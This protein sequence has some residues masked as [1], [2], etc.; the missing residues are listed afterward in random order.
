MCAFSLSRSSVLHVENTPRGNRGDFSMSQP[1]IVV[2]VEGGKEEGGARG[3]KMIQYQQIER[4]CVL[5]TL[6]DRRHSNSTI[7]ALQKAVS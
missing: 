4:K 2:V 1:F 5:Y 6:L 7:Y 3:K